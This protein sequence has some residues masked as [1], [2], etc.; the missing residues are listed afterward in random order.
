MV[1]DRAARIE[2]IVK[3]PGGEAAPDSYVFVLPLGDGGIDV[4][5]VSSDG[6]FLVN[7]VK[8]GQYLVGANEEIPGQGSLTWCELVEVEDGGEVSVQGVL[9]P[10]AT[11]RGVIVDAEGLPVGDLE[12]RARGLDVDHFVRNATTDAAGRCELPKLYPWRFT[13]EGVEREIVGAVD[14]DLGDGMGDVDVGALVAQ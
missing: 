4:P 11:V 7:D 12:L 5:H 3:R 1:L 6:R 9:A 8:P 13:I 2:G 14:V 10:A